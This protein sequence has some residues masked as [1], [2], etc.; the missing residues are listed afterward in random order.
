MTYQIIVDKYY[1]EQRGLV[2]LRYRPN[3][4]IDS[5]KGA[6][7]EYRSANGR[8]CK[9]KFYENQNGYL[10]TSLAL[11]DHTKLSGRLNRLVYSNVYGEIPKGYEVDHIDRNRKNNFPDNLRLVTKSEN[12]LNKNI[13][14]E[15]NGYAILTD[16][17][18]KVILELVLTHQK[19]KAEIAKEYGVSFATIKAIRSGRNW[20][21]V[22]RDIFAKYGIQK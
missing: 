13:K 8:K 3:L 22:T 2:K 6:W 11:D 5:E 12:N 1:S 7:I 10:W 15:K 21:S 17:K 19:T 16:D 14:G 20:I 9:M 18:V 4:V